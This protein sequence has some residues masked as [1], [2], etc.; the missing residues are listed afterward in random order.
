[1]RKTYCKSVVCILASVLMLLSISPIASATDIMPIYE[2]V[3]SANCTFSISSTGKAEAYF[4]VTAQVADS[5]HGTMEIKKLVDGEWV[6]V[7]S[8]TGSNTQRLSNTYTRYVMSGYF[9]K[10]FVTVDIYTSN[11][12]Y[13]ETVYLESNQVFY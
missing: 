11:G 5:V 12:V 6:T 7:T 13:C 1:M 2:R 10:L 3:S 4:S 9:Y 8:W